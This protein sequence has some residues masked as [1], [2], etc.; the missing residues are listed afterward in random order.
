MTENSNTRPV[1]GLERGSFADPGTIAEEDLRKLVD[2]LRLA[3]LI[4][5][6]VSITM[7]QNMAKVV[8]DALE[9]E[10]DRRHRPA[11][12]GSGDTA[13]KLRKFNEMADSVVEE[14]PS[15]WPS[16]VFAAVALA[17]ILLF[18]AT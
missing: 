5:P 16:V 17:T 9:A 18:V 13:A 14:P 8:A 7:P 4:Y 3:L 2:D 6:A 15:I 11:V 12:V 10:V 1:V